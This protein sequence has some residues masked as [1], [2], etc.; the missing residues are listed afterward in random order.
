MNARVRCEV[1]DARSMPTVGQC[2]LTVSKP[3][4]KERQVSEHENI[5]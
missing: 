1:A 4:L 2:M 5:M 3:E